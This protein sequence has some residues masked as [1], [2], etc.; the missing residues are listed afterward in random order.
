[1][2]KVLSVRVDDDLAQW[3]ESYAQ[4]RDASRTQVHEAALV[5]F[6][7]LCETGVPDLPEP[8][9]G[10][11]PKGDAVSATRPEPAS[12]APIEQARANAFARRAEGQGVTAEEYAARMRRR[13]ELLG[14]RP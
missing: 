6:R 13:D 14:R 3:V 1:M 9:A 5:A 4:Q 12:V 8:K 10:G 11:R 2:A 7:G